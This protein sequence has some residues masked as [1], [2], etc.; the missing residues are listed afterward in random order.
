MTRNLSIRVKNRLHVL[1]LIFFLCLPPN[2]WAQ[3]NPVDTLTDR[4]FTGTFD[5]EFLS[6]GTMTFVLFQDG[7]MKGSWYT[8]NSTI[9]IDTK[10][11]Y[12]EKNGEIVMAAFGSS[13]LRGDI[14]AN[15]MVGHAAR[16]TG[17][18]LC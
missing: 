3:F 2:G 1:L 7:T 18:A 17:T 12:I 13:L 16:K 15:V 6:D 8:E 5:S 10:G 4:F 9:T 11:H 14:E